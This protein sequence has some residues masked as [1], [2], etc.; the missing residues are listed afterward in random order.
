MRTCSVRLFTS[1]CARTSLASQ[2]FPALKTHAQ[3]FKRFHGHLVLFGLI[4]FAL[5]ALTY[6]DVSLG[7]SELQQLDQFW[8]E[9]TATVQGNPDLLND[10]LCPA[11]QDGNRELPRPTADSATRGD[12][13]PKKVAVTCRMLQSLD[14][15]RYQTREALTRLFRCS[16]RTWESALLHVWCWHWVLAAGVEPAAHQSQPAPGSSTAR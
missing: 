3:R 12:E 7:R 16:E 14:R 11:Y 10:A 8:K 13:A 1:A 15:A 6:W 4:W 5:T 2:T 9:R